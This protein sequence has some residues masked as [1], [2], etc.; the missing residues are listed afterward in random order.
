METAAVVASGDGTCLLLYNPDFFV[1]LGLDVRPQRVAHQGPQR[2]LGL[3]RPGGE[4]PAA[5]AEGA[6]HRAGRTPLP[7]IGLRAVDDARE[8]RPVGVARVGGEAFPQDRGA[9]GP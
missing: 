2:V 7:Y 8:P 6:Q 1:A 5:G 3:P 9:V 4:R